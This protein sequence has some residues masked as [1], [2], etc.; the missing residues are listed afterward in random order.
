MKLTQ[1]N[2]NNFRCIQSVT[3]DVE[4][5]DDG[6]TY[7][8]LGINESGKSSFLKAI[9]L[10][11]NGKA[12][13][14]EDFF[15]DQEPIEISLKYKMTEHEIKDLKEALSEK[16]H[17]DKFLLQELEIE[18]VKIR[19]L[20]APNIN[21][22]KEILEILHLK[23]PSFA[24]YTYANKTVQRKQK[25]VADQDDLDLYIFF[26]DFF[27]D[28]FWNL[29]H[30]IT[31]WKSTPEYLL[32]D[33]IDLDVFSTS[34]QKTSVPLFN[35]F[36]LAGIKEIKK[37][38]TKLKSSV[39]RQNL[40]DLLS[41]SVTKHIN[42]V[43][44]EHQI[45][46]KF[47]INNNKLT[48]LVEDRDVKFKV[49]TTGQ[50][51]DGFR[52]FI[53]F[54]LTLSAENLNEKLSNAILLLDEPETHL[55]PSAQLNLM[56]ELIKLSKNK[57]NNIVFFATHSNY[58]IDKEQ[59][60]RCFKVIKKKNDTTYLEKILRVYTSYSE[61]NYEVFGIATSDYHNELYGYL[62][63][64]NKE[65]LHLLP[66]IKD[67]FNEKKQ[68]T[69]QVSLSTFIRHSIHHPENKSNKKYTEADLKRS[70]QTLRS[71]K[72]TE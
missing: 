70:I 36:G 32:L 33:E 51:S 2:I 10:I 54:L 38:I 71:L 56:D 53:S 61:V 19:V 62:E 28:Y 27:E 64:V 11:D 31:F 12:E 59:I 55:H 41:D 25:D 48:F 52:Q 68:Q 30:K 43:W 7:T 13:Y 24:F 4:P 50:R 23:K 26:E 5:I 20:Y 39:A 65:K 8:L 17:F 47:N 46:I 18:E 57:N 29:A 6:H 69:E 3:F 49:K 42:K 44:P 9:S 67:W 63:D 21:P 37:E 35:C 14:P 1:I 66:K 40:S 15:D 72:Y 16:H 22:A 34:L 60:D 58:M 45:S